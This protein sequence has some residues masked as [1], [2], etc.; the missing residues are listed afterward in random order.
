MSDDKT[1]PKARKQPKAKKPPKVT[2][3]P[4]PETDLPPEQAEK[5][6]G[7]VLRDPQAARGTITWEG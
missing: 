6:R 5:A 3:L 2:K 1:Q 7:G 4:Q